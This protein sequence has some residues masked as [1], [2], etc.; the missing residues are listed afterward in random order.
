M[1]TKERVTA[2]RR[3]E[4]EESRDKKI[5]FENDFREV[6]Q[7]FFT[8]QLIPEVVGNYRDTGA[9]MGV[10]ENT[11]NFTEILMDNYRKIGSY[12]KNNLRRK[13][14][15][16]KSF[17]TKQ[18]ANDII[19][20]RLETFY[21]LHAAKQVTELNDTT[22]DEFSNNLSKIR[23]DLTDQGIDIT[24]AAIAERLEEVSQERARTR[25]Q[26]IAQ[27]ETQIVSEQVKLTEAEV[28]EEEGEVSDVRKQW[29]TMDDPSVRPAHAAANGQ[30]VDV[31]DDF[32]VGGERLNMPGDP[33]GSAGNVI[34]CRCNAVL[35]RE[36][37]V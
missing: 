8:E 27:T 10:E 5:E 15:S 19:D 21:E 12:F 3:R 13:I 23:R 7:Q 28:L 6:I 16:G 14:E 34:N 33:A 26:M 25:S 20:E 29:I 30:L 2:E 32:V 35:V 24:D 11:D 1:E 18:N 4:A 31:E 9:I 17:E 37:E 36:G 22:M